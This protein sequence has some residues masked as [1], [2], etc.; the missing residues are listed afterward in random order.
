L[1]YEKFK[2]NHLD[3]IYRLLYHSLCLQISIFRRNRAQF[4]KY[5]QHQPLY[6]GSMEPEE[7]V[8]AA[9]DG[10]IV[11]HNRI[12]IFRHIWTTKFSSLAIYFMCI[13]ICS[14]PSLDRE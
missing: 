5:S 12:S 9:T 1:R 6:D 11:Y 14:D 13:W 7:W 3:N 4:C 8:F 2:I 10:R